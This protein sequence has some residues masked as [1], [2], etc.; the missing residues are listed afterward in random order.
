MRP[1]LAQIKIQFLVTCLFTLLFVLIIFFSL[2]IS[3]HFPKTMIQSFQQDQLSLVKTVAVGIQQIINHLNLEIA[4]LSTLKVLQQ[5][6]PSAY[7]G[8][9]QDVHRILAGKVHSIYKIDQNKQIQYMYP[10]SQKEIGKN[11]GNVRCVEE[12]YQNKRPTISPCFTTEDGIYSLAINYPIFGNEIEKDV[13]GIL[14]CII[15]MDILTGLFLPF[16]NM[17][18]KGTIWIIDQEGSIIYHPDPTLLSKNY[19]NIRGKIQVKKRG[20]SNGGPLIPYQAIKKGIGAWGIYPFWGKGRELYAFTPLLVNSK[21]WLIGITTPYSSLYSPIKN[22]NHNIFFLTLAIFSIFALGGYL[23]HYSYKKRILLEKETEFLKQEVELEN[24]IKKERDRLYNLFNSMAD[25]VLVIN[26]DYQVEFMNKTAISRFGD[27]IGKPC[28]QGLCGFDPPCSPCPLSHI[29]SP[30][31]EQSLMHYHDTRRNRW[32]EISVAPL[33]EA[34]QKKSIIEIVRDVTE[35]KE[36]EQKLLAS[37]KKYRTLVN[38]TNDLIMM[39]DLQGTVLFVSESIENLL[40]YQVEEFCHKKFQQFL[41]DNPLNDPWRKEIQGLKDLQRHLRP[42]LLECRTKHNDK[43]LLEANESKVF[44]REG[45]EKQ[46]MGVYRDIT[47]RKRL[48]EQLLESERLRMLSLTK[49]FRFGEIIGKNPKMQEIYELIEVVSQSKA[50]VLIQG[51]S[52]TGKE[53]VARAIHYQGTLAKGPFV[54]ISCSVLSEN[55]LESELFGHVKGAFTGAI[56]DKT[57][58]FELANRGT[59]FLDEIADMSLNLQTKLLRVL[60]ERKFEKVGGEKI[61]KVDVRIITATNKD[62]KEEV[63]KE[64]FREDLYYRLNVVKIKLPPLRE[65]MDDLP[66]LVTHFIEKFKQ[67]TGKE[68]SDLSREAMRILSR[69]PWPGNIR[70]LEHVIEHAFVKCNK[71]IIQA[72]HLPKDMLDNKASDIIKSGVKRGF[73]KDQIEKDILLNMLNECDWNQI[74]VMDKLNMSRPTLW[75]KMK[76]YGLNKKTCQLVTS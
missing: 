40:G 67:E 4:H 37:E 33:L 43:V 61:I 66:L 31:F 19:K 14:R 39:Q 71:N 45:Q 11:M 9:F 74:L 17:R 54:G 28:F 72:E 3:Q 1:R 62:I 70:E 36:L 57:G 25:S 73:S 29:E 5:E 27:Q 23:F 16:L 42:H 24:E 20:R 64:R 75:R 47:E 44:D 18:D 15:P 76:K 60:Q 51:E 8:L 22:N 69:Y 26:T 10:Y 49:K 38:H 52:G 13:V 21:K 2:K 53:L 6:K 50:T 48:E 65:R 63:V 58:R 68:I 30:S 55:L 34:G 35:E 56:K 59:L 12:V 41:T 32:Y 46:I 7:S